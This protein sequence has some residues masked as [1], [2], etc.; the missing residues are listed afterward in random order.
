MGTNTTA[1]AGPNYGCL[2]SQP[3]PYWYYLK[4]LDP[5]NITIAL[6]SP[7]GNDI[8]FAIWGPFSSPTAPC[9]SQLTASCSSCPN[10]TSL[11]WPNSTY[12]AGNLVDCS[13]DPAPS[14]VVHISNAQ[15]GQY[16]LLLIT[17][18]SNTPGNLTFSQSNAVGTPGVNYG[19]TDCSIIN[20][21]DITNITV[22]V[23]A[24]NPATN[25]YS[26]SGTITYN[27]APTTGTLG[28]TVSGGGSQ[29]I[30]GPFGTSS[31]YSISGLVSDGASHTI[32]AT[33]SDD[34]FCTYTITFTAPNPCS[35]CFSN[36]GADFSVC[37]LT[38]TLAG[39][40][41][42]TNTNETWTCTPSTGV[43]INQPNQYNTIVT[44]PSAGTYTFTWT[45]TNAS[46][47]TC[48]DAVVVTF[49]PVPTSTFTAGTVP[50]FNNSSAVNYTGTQIAG[51]TYTWNFDGGTGG[52]TGPGPYNITWAT[53]GSHT[54][55]LT[56]SA[57]GCT[58]TQS[59]QTV[60]VPAQL[61]VN[62]STSNVTCASGTNGQANVNVSGG[63]P[64][65][66][67]GW[68]NGSGPPFAA[69]PYTVTITDIN[70][71][72]ATTPFTITEPNSITILPSQTNVT[73]F[74]GNN[75]TASV[76]VSGGTTP[77]TYNWSPGGFTGNGTNTYSSLPAGSYTVTIADANICTTTN[78][79]T[80]TEPS[81]F[82]ASVL[83]QN[84][85][86]CQ[87]VC[88]GSA[89]VQANGGSPGYT[90]AW[91]GGQTTSAVSGLCSGSY[92]VTITDSQNCTATTTITLTDPPGV[93]ISITNTTNVSCYGQCNGTATAQAT[94]GS[95]GVY[96]Y[97]WSNGANGATANNLCAGN[98]TVTVSDVNGCTAST[99][100]TITEPTQLT[101]VAG[102]QTGVLCYGDC[103]GIGSVNPAGGTPPYQY[104]WSGSAFN[105]Q[106]NPNLCAASHFVTV[107]DASGCTAST[108][109]II[110]GPSELVIQNINATP[111]SCN[112]MSD[113]TVTI[114]VAGGY[115]SYNYQ[116]G[117]YSQ[118]T[119][120]FTGLSAGNYG[121]TVTDANG[122]TKVAN[123]TVNQPNPITVASSPSFTLCNG[124]TGFI[125]TVVTG[126]TQPYQYT[127]N[128]IPGQSILQVNPQ[129]QT[130]YNVQVTDANGCTSNIAST[131]VNVTPPVVLDVFASPAAVCPGDPVMLNVSI[132][133]GAGEPY[134]IRYE[135]QIVVPPVTVY[136]NQTGY[137]ELTVEDNCGS[138]ASDTVL[139]TVYP[140]PVVTFTSD[141]NRGCQPLEVHF[142]QYSSVPGISYIWNFGDNSYD[143]ISYDVNPTHKFR[144]PGTFNVSLTVTSINGC[145]S[146]TTIPQM[147]T[148]W[149][150]PDSR[151]D[152]DPQI[153][154]I[155]KPQIQF[156][157]LSTGAD[158]YI[159]HFGDGDSASITHPLHLYHN[160]NTFNV[161]LIAITNKGCKDTSYLNVT[162]RDEYSFYAPSAFSPNNDWVND[163]F[164]VL[165]H[166]IDV[167]EFY[168]AVYDRW[169]N[170]MFE[171]DK[172]NPLNPE[173]YGWHGTTVS[174]Q[175]APIGTYTW[176]CK[177]KDGMNILHEKAGTVTLIR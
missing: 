82:T 49:N 15:T 113:G 112:G 58:S 42:A 25:Q 7:T 134:I 56:V 62:V 99:S 64:T 130:T 122:C 107:T 37:G 78:T 123:I 55:T 40:H 114:T 111:T 36:A 135:G 61:Q 70:G 124:Q 168:L 169:G 41:E 173:Q 172:Y 115:A 164:F 97:L 38:A 60:N 160:I 170:I 177:Y 125:Q 74:G 139:I 176:L 1:E 6:N 131:T 35:Y 24:C 20:P 81:S 19:T 92:V 45:I 44:V 88:N 68:S 14:E 29:T 27:D 110:P 175:M 165:G 109:V 73:C 57:N 95:S 108:M 91:P 158:W 146:T 101:V 133:Q 132:T 3:N 126:G 30:N 77:Y 119:N 28:V 104:Y 106:T 8:D 50:C 66:T 16:Y 138:T 72:T 12:P 147:I 152:A 53:A 63:T 69:G 128:G 121:V 154:S 18:Y 84:N 13:Y 96:N 143:Q 98:F 85:P 145:V 116:L 80:I 87:G 83:S 174:K 65:Y 89:A 136:P 46:G 159:W 153:V 32:T 4:I 94:G 11:S 144:V 100:A 9:T 52:G 150:K 33:F 17:N 118:T 127:W 39:V 79:I 76:N 149:P 2:Y 117:P 10:N 67:Y 31:N 93:S 48:Y 163:A 137:Y 129:N 26:I 140:V 157:N 161:S 171:T 90:Y 71:C 166:G 75:G 47:L 167:N 43:N 86:A 142:N 148:V 103:N 162:V 105:Q 51:A 23:G 22:T 59:S 156:I 102:T 141:T 5:G 120:I 21:C 155:I 54:I 151:F 34:P